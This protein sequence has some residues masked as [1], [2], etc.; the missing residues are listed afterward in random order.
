MTKIGYR[1]NIDVDEIVAA[2]DTLFGTGS[3]A[4][5]VQYHTRVGVATGWREGLYVRTN[6]DKIPRGTAIATFVNGV[7]PNQKKGNHAAFFL[8]ATTEGIM[9]VDQYDTLPKPH[10]RLIEYK[11][12]KGADGKYPDPSNNG[13]AFSVIQLQGDGW[14]N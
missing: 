5:L 7:Y 3:C 8:N 11:G 9:V 14:Q 1:P 12:G 4:E 13:D 2:H 6:A 10:E